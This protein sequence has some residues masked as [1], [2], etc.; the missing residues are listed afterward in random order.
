M[1][2]CRAA[3]GRQPRRVDRQIRDGYR[4]CQS[5]SQNLMW[6]SSSADSSEIHFKSTSA[7]LDP[8]FGESAARKRD[9]L[10]RRWLSYQED[11]PDGMFGQMIA[12][13]TIHNDRAA[14]PIAPG[15][16]RP[17]TAT[18][19]QPTHPSANVQN[20]RQ[21]NRRWHLQAMTSEEILA[22]IRIPMELAGARNIVRRREIGAS[23]HGYKR[24]PP[25]SF[26]RRS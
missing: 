1:S 4:K 18:R 6:D 17:L 8:P 21:K 23:A 14:D 5:A 20:P 24:A 16:A 12:A 11:G 26:S 7:H 10:P 2:A 3:S 9:R 22:T 25:K 15:P 19:M 13:R